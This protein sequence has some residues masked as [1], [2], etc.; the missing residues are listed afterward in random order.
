MR[1]FWTGGYGAYMTALADEH[2][3]NGRQLRKRLKSAATQAERERLLHEIEELD[4][5]YRKRKKA[6]GRCLF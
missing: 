2:E 3:K 4:E 1:G 5:A 6:V